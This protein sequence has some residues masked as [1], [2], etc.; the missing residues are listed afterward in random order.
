M[1]RDQDTQIERS[2]RLLRV[3]DENTES[4]EAGPSTSSSPNLNDLNNP[5]FDAN[6]NE[7][8]DK[9]KGKEV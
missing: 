2:R 6:N 4:T 8:Q 5:N 9:G 3:R 7:S 1:E